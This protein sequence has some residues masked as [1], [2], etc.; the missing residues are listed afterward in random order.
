MFV[1]QVE[2][3][4]RA[5]LVARHGRERGAVATVEAL[6]WAWERWEKVRSLESPVAYL[7]KVGT[8]RTRLRV[9]FPQLDPPTPDEG[10]RFEPGL[11]RALARLS[12]RQR[13]C[14]VAIAGYG[15]TF[16]ETADLLSIRKATVQRHFERGIARLREELGVDI[17]DGVTNGGD[18]VD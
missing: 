17:A 14:V 9:A 12:A 4:L 1:R 13:S 18:G 3:R 5:A 6:S 8:S 11:D 15:Y 7:V 2:P 16:S 10:R